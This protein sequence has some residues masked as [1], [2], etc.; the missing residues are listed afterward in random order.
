MNITVEGWRFVPHSYAVVNQFFCLELLKRSQ[1]SLFHRD[2]PFYDPAW[3]MVDEL[4]SPEQE[5]SLKQ[6]RTPTSLEDVL[7]RV[8][9]P[10]NLQSI[11]E[12]TYVFATSECYIVPD[13]FIVGNQSVFQAIKNSQSTIVTCSNWSLEGFLRSGIPI[14]RTSLVPL[15]FNP[16]L[17]KPLEDE[18]RKQLRSSKHLEDYFVFLN[19]G[20]ISENKGVDI[21]LKAF[22]CVASQYPQARL[23]LKG[24]DN[25]YSSR[26]N[27]DYLLNGLTETEKN[28]VLPKLIYNGDTL[29]FADCAQLYQLADAYISS[30]RAEAFNLPVLEAAACG[31]PVICTQGGSTDD[32]THPN[33]ALT[34]ESQKVF[35]VTRG[36]GAHWIL[37]P[38]C[39]HL[40]AQ[41]IEVIENHQFRTQAKQLGP[42]FVGERFTWSKVTDRL[43]ECFGRQALH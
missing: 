23:F 42:A 4:F 33:F 22:A 41:M 32:F 43:L 30:Y 16:D 35:R 24:L 10:Y 25:L 38:S 9:F 17:C 20:A 36:I 7:W 13:C 28:L 18:C 11:G 2:L 6:L 37:E 14:E 19:I 26:S 40:V 34:I 39:E 31:L 1:V 21:L 29:S 3:S 12:N 8:A 15:G 5:S 27:L